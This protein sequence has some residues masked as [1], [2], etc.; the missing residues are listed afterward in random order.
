MFA[1]KSWTPKIWT[2]HHILRSVRDKASMLTLHLVKS[3]AT[4]VLLLFY[5][6]E[7][8]FSSFCLVEF[9][10]KRAHLPV[11]SSMVKR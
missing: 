1:P 8:R 4:S 9:R 10:D 7:V 2:E 5:I 3:F 11:I 6:S